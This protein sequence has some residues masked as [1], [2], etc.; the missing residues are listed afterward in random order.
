MNR[1]LDE[2]FFNRDTKAVAK[3]LL[4]KFLIRKIGNKV[5][6]AMITETEAYDGLLDKA[7]H[8]YKGRTERTNVMFG[9]PGYFYIYL[10]Y[11]M[12]YMLNVVTR[13][14]EYPA[15]VL[16]RGV[17]SHDGPGKVTR[18]FKIGKVFNDKKVS[19]ET[20]LWF[21]DRGIIISKKKIK[22]TPRIGVSY[23]GPV[24]SQKKLRFILEP[25]NLI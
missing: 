19:K 18:F 14:K 16:I 9:H 13:E 17:I 4:G 23:A 8:A 12:Y 7:S 24:W 10:V 15:A 3:D 22:K 2:K 25:G 6:F 21:E 1:V 5:V 20:G 11:G